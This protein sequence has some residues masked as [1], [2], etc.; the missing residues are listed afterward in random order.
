MNEKT[1]DLKYWLR[2][3]WNVK[4]S[5]E[6]Y[7]YE[8]LIENSF[9]DILADNAR[10]TGELATAQKQA[11]FDDLE[12]C[13][14]E[15]R[16]EDAEIDN[17]RLAAELAAAQE[18]ERWIPVSEN[19]SNWN[20]SYLCVTDHDRVTIRFYRGGGEWNDPNVSHWRPLPAAPAQEEK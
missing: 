20:T 12:I 13:S 1:R 17:R 11:Q 10:L 8:D 9:E 6:A 18:R 4:T 7:R 15:G 2:Q 19:P 5:E 3:L 14:L 16:L